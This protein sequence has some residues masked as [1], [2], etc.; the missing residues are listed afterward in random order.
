MAGTLA[1]RTTMSTVALASWA[2]VILEESAKLRRFHERNVLFEW[3]ANA[4]RAGAHKRGVASD[5]AE[6]G[7]G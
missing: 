1:N 6:K 2:E 3:A 5:G 4:P 7:R